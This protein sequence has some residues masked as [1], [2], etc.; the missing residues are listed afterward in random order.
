MTSVQRVVTLINGK[1]LRPYI[2]CSH[3]DSA[4]DKKHFYACDNVIA[5]R[6]AARCLANTATRAAENMSESCVKAAVLTC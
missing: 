1:C 2:T 6:N 4:H 3:S 5:N